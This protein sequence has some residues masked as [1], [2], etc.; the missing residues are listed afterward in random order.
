MYHVLMKK[1]DLHLHSRHSS[2]SRELIENYCLAAIRNKI[3]I[4]CIT[5]HIECAG[6]YLSMPDYNSQIAECNAAREKFED[7]V[8]LLL[9][10][11]FG[12]PHLHP[13][14][15]SKISKLPYDMI[16]GSVHN[17]LDNYRPGKNVSA[18][19]MSQMHYDSTLE[20]LDYGGF[21]VLGHLDFPRK[22]SSDFIEDLEKTRLILRKCVEKG[23]VPEINTSTMR[24]DGKPLPTMEVIKVYAELGG[25]FVTIN[26]DSHTAAY[27]GSY[28]D[29]ILRQLPAGIRP[30]YFVNREMHLLR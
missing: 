22:F 13:E 3:D 28:F 14:V 17:V 29:E 24:R 20:M 15:F 8:T 25:K 9:G 11:E 18:Q 5:D 2:D 7:Q 30:V 4:I 1:A 16:I 23:I 10:A 6:D 27:T 19:K 26:S 12:E 21:Q